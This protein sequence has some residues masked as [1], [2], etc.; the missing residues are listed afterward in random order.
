MLSFKLST[1]QAS[2]VVKFHLLLSAASSASCLFFSAIILFISFSKLLYPSFSTLN[3]SRMWAAIFCQAF[4]IISANR[5]NID[6]TIFLGF[7]TFSL[8]HKEILSANHSAAPFLSF[9]HSAG[10]LGSA[11]AMAYA[12]LRAG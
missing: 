12:F 1:V 3:R 8:A 2:V 9:F 7:F 10:A 5:L 11:V 4:S 6:S